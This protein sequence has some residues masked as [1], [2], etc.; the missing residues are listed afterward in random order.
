[1]FSCE[2]CVISKN[3]FYTEH[4]WATVSRSRIEWVMPKVLANIS[5]SLTVL[6][7]LLLKFSLKYFKFSCIICYPLKLNF[8]SKNAFSEIMS[9]IKEKHSYFSNKIKSLSLICYLVLVAWIL[10][11]FFSSCCNPVVISKVSIIC[12]N[13]VMKILKCW[14]ALRVP[15]FIETCKKVSLMKSFFFAIWCNCLK[16]VF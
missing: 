6:L 15:C 1:M 12:Q 2:F 3:N 5:D 11:C 14:D 13:Y 16:N 10:S 4:L 7:N 8:T 9:I